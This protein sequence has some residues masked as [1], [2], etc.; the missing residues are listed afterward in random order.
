[1]DE[2]NGIPELTEK[3]KLELDKQIARLEP[4]VFKA[5]QEYEKLLDQLAQTS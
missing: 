2:K 5:H 3:E 1:M 4:K